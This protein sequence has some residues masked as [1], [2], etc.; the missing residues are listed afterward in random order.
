MPRCQSGAL[1]A[2]ESQSQHCSPWRVPFLRL[3]RME[4]DWVDYNVNLEMQSHMLIT[5][6]RPEVCPGLLVRLRGSTMAGL[7]PVWK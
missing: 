3:S 4:E 6:L 7:V 1:A 2:Q 5:A